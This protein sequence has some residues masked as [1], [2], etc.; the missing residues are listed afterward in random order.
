MYIAEAFPLN[1]NDTVRHYE[2][3]IQMKKLT[4][5]VG[6]TAVNCAPRDAALL[7]AYVQGFRDAVESEVCERDECPPLSPAAMLFGFLCWTAMLFF[8]FR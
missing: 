4:A 5:S 1:Y 7:R 6:N 2:R 3:T 8:V